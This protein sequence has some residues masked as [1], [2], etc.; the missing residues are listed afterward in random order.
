M[1]NMDEPV[2]VT[3]TDAEP[4]DPEL[5]TLRTHL[6]ALEQQGRAGASWFYWVGGLSLVNSAIMLFGGGIT[7]VFGLGITSIADDVG[8]DVVRQNPQIATVVKG[9]VFGF[10]LFVVAIFA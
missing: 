1:S 4:V 6:T 9:L 5:A 3:P 7:F 10:D 8:A 2:P